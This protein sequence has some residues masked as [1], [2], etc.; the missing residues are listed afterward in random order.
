MEG[1]EKVVPFELFQQL[2]AELN[3]LKKKIFIREKGEWVAERALAEIPLD[4]TVF[5]QSN[6]ERKKALEPYPEDTRCLWQGKSLEQEQRRRMGKEAR[7]EEKLIFGFEKEVLEALRPLLDILDINFNEERRKNL[8]ENGRI[9]EEV[10][11]AALTAYHLL[12]STLASMEIRRKELALA[13]IHPKFAKL[14]R[15]LVGRPLITGEDKERI[16]KFW[17]DEQMASELTSEI[18]YD[19]SLNAE[20]ELPPFRWSSQCG[21]TLAAQFESWIAENTGYEEQQRDNGTEVPNSVEYQDIDADADADADSDS[22]S[23]NHSHSHKCDGNNDDVTEYE[24]SSWREAPVFQGTMEDV[25]FLGIE[26]SGEWVETGGPRRKQLFEKNKR[27]QGREREGRDSVEDTQ[28]ISHEECSGGGSTSRKRRGSLFDVISSTEERWEMERSAGSSTTERNDQEGPLQDGRPAHSEGDSSQGRLDDVFGLTGC[29]Q[30]YPNTPGGQEIPTI[31]YPRETLSIQGDAVWTYVGTENFYEGYETDC[32]A[33]EGARAQV[34]HLSGRLA[35]HGRDE[36]VND[37]KYQD[38]EGDFRGIWLDHQHG[39]IG[40]ETC[41]TADLFGL[42]NRQPRD[43]LTCPS[44]EGKGHQERHY[45][46]NGGCKRRSLDI[47]AASWS[48]GKDFGN[49]RGDCDDE[50]IYSPAIEREKSVVAEVHLGSGY[51]SFG[52]G[53]GRISELDGVSSRLQWARDYSGPAGVD[54]RDRR[55]AMGMGSCGRP[56]QQSSRFL[57]SGLGRTA[58]QREGAPGLIVSSEKASG[59]TIQED[60]RQNRQYYCHGVRQQSRWQICEFNSNSARSVEMGAAE[61]HS[62]SSHLYPGEGQHYSGS[63]IT[64]EETGQIGLDPEQDTISE[65]G[66]KMGSTH[67][68]SICEEGERT[69]TAIL[70]FDTGRSRDWTRRPADGVTSGR[71]C[72][73]IPAIFSDTDTASEGSRGEIDCNTGGSSMEITTLVAKFTAN[74]ISEAFETTSPTAGELFASGS[75]TTDGSKRMAFDSFQNFRTSR[76]S[77]GLCAEEWKLRL[78]SGA[79]R[80]WD[81]IYLTLEKQREMP[82]DGGEYYDRTYCGVFWAMSMN[83]IGMTDWKRVLE[84]LHWNGL[85][86]LQ[87]YIG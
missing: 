86:G 46:D 4:P 61:G 53:A 32:K 83:Q 34:R 2:Q 63:T 44:A 64:T 74:D 47:E 3:M 85:C 16:E 70:Q 71:E 20:P 39:E 10:C 28:R 69:I 9:L 58:Q 23:H 80:E 43:G 45:S 75:S 35:D 65:G 6:F 42:S 68:R 40:D 36:G 22:D 49:V 30:P 76:T 7:I 56:G 5:H 27:I 48:L 17:K 50:A 66:K 38:R 79:V 77:E 33:L 13:A 62:A 11:G 26:D 81:M 55:I 18:I 15:P 54:H 12:S 52:S 67:N 87:Y 31:L 29:I 82:R 41:K 51:R 57:G 21:G 59:T 14:A 24:D 72:L 8:I 1:H 25:G 73:R 84:K 19:D 78:M 37:D 60:P